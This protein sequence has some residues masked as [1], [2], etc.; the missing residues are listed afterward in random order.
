MN[1]SLF[2]AFLFLLF[3]G[4]VDHGPGVTTNLSRMPFGSVDKT[5]WASTRSLIHW[6]SFSNSSTSLNFIPFFTSSNSPI[7]CNAIFRGSCGQPST[8]STGSLPYSGWTTRMLPLLQVT[9]Q[10]RTSVSIPIGRI[11]SIC[12][13]PP[14]A[15]HLQETSEAISSDHLPA[16]LAPCGTS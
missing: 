12:P 16:R 7:N 9:S 10:P 5:G 13:P 14:K 11:G 3:A 1:P 4:S 8:S 6:T 2:I 15:S